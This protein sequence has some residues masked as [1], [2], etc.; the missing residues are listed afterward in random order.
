MT[1]RN[2]SCILQKIY[3]YIY[4]NTQYV[5]CVLSFVM[6][7]SVQLFSVYVCRY[8]VWSCFGSCMTV[9][10]WRPEKSFIVVPWVLST[11]YCGTRTLMAWSSLSRIGCLVS[12]SQ[13]SSSF[14]FSNTRNLDPSL[15]AWHVRWGLAV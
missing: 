2:T 9:F 4:S 6:L 15:H 10:I 5:I 11:L 8:V 14:C 13:G 1:L 3:I 12:F 7:V